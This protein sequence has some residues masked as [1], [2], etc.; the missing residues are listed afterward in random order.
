MFTKQPKQAECTERII[1]AILPPSFKMADDKNS[2]GYKY[3][4]LLYGVELDYLNKK[5]KELYNNSFINS[6]DLSN[7]LTLYSATIS[8][9]PITNFINASGSIPIKITNENEFYDGSPTRIIN[10]GSVRIPMYYSTY[11]GILVASGAG[12]DNGFDIGFNK[13]C[14][15]TL[16]GFMGLEYIRSDERGSGYLV[17]SSDID[18][19]TAFK[20]GLYPVFAV[21]VGTNFAHT[22]DYNYI[23]GMFTGIKNQ[24]YSGTYKYEFLYPINS[25]TLS[26]KYPLTREV[27]DESGTVYVIDHYTPYH[28]WIKDETGSGVAIVDY[29]GDYYYDNGGNKI[30]YRTAYNN[31][32]G[33]NNYTVAYLDLEHIP[34]SGTM[35]LYDIDILDSSGN[36]TEIPY[37]GKPLYYYKSRKMFLGTA[38]GDADGAFDPIYVG[39]DSIVPSGKGFSAN[40][41]GSGCTL[42]QT[43]SWD[44]LHESGKID[45][46]TMT[47]VDGSG[48]ITNRIK[49]SGYYS[50]YMVE[51]KYKTYDGIRYITSPLASNYISLHTSSPITTV[52]QSGTLNELEYEFT[53]DP[54]QNEPSKVITFDGLKVRP[55]SKIYK[56]SFDLPMK[57]SEGQVTGPLYQ[58]TNKLYAGYSNEFVP[59]ITTFRHTSIN[60]LFDTAVSGNLIETD[61][62][63]NGNDL[64]YSGEYPIYK[65]NYNDSYGKK[66]IKTNGEAYYYKDNISYIKVSDQYP[67]QGTYFQFDCKLR[68]VSSGRLLEL[69]DDYFDKYIYFDFDIDGKLRIQADG[70]QFTGKEYINFNENRK[71]FIVKYAPDDISSNVPTFKLYYKEET[72]P[73]YR[74]IKLSQT[75]C[76]DDSVGSTTIRIFKNC[77]V[78]I[79]GFK[80]FYEA[81]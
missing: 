49:I 12:F 26:G 29:S 18:Q 54:N 48:S 32:Y 22:G 8:G 35:H 78:D 72:D 75:T 31:P 77:N 36:A 70:Y 46:G 13:E 68:L 11:T 20:S 3:I 50:R 73:W 67:S 81:Q 24:Q 41:E 30:Y 52:N 1:K 15:S 55:Y 9:V 28:G 25:Q 37:T 59:Q 19:E 74:E 51:Y 4:N 5:M 7:E 56:M 65:I 23:Y 63:S 39:Y 14:W 57:F 64:R 6:F 69:F 21:D 34:I 80:L 53:K 71:S 16:T 61:V 2:N 47:Y 43:T 76:A 17:I 45:E 58:N 66:M 38:S 40:M 62:S 27:L 79:G 44:Y 10:T 33:Y 60:C 42:L